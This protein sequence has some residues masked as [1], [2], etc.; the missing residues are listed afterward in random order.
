MELEEG[1]RVITYGNSHKFHEH[2]VADLISSYFFQRLSTG[3][4]EVAGSS[5]THGYVLG[6]LRLV[7]DYFR[8]QANKL[9]G[10]IADG[11]LRLNAIMPAYMHHNIMP[12]EPPSV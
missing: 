10:C 11:D 9:K 7:N 5:T 8:Q 12:P 3:D 1:D 6:S 4:Q 2:L